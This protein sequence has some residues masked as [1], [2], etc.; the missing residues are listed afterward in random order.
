MTTLFISDLH[1]DPSRPAV[2]R[3][4]LQLLEK[5]AAEADAL[6]ILGDFFDV[7]IGDDDDAELNL[8]V[9]DALKQLTRAGTPVY[10]MHGNRD[11]LLGQRFCQQSGCQLIPDPTLVD[12][13][14]KPLL[15]MHGDTLCTDDIKY[16]EFRAQ[17]RSE[18]WQ[19]ALLSHPVEKRRILA[20]QMRADS[21]AASSNKAE[22]IMD[23]NQAEVLRVLQEH[24]VDLLIH[25]HTHRPAIHEI[26]LGSKLANAHRIVLGDWEQN[27]W[28][29]R[30]HSD[31]SYQLEKFVIS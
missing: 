4:F 16:M 22:D 15:L 29:V 1:L 13:Y 6:Y 20:Q 19:T 14:G 23:V 27:G 24:H 28:L 25:G 8:H 5:Q 7:W 18:A 11:F 17:C 9:I 21:K 10:V 30:Y 2:I 26:N 31:N 12:L 3:A